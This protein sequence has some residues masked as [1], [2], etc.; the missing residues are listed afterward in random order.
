MLSTFLVPLQ[1]EVEGHIVWRNDRPSSTTLCRPVHLEYTKKTAEASRAEYQAVEKEIAQLQ[2]TEVRTRQGEVHVTHKLLP[3]M[4]DG[5]AVC[6]LTNTRSPATCTT[7][8][9]TPSQ[10]NWLEVSRAV[11]LESYLFGLS[12]LHARIRCFE[13]ILHLGYRLDIKQRKVTEKLKPAV[14]MQKKVIQ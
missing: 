10:M 13:L 12:P 5:K 6:A 1:L 11:K 7:C 9:A 8:G 4:M 14:M 3:T 2:V